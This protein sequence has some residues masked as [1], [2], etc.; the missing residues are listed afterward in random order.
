M[1]HVLLPLKRIT[2]YRKRNGKK[3]QRKKKIK[4]NSKKIW[5]IFLQGM[6]HK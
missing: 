5:K 2:A 4:S 6:I 1:K 3:R